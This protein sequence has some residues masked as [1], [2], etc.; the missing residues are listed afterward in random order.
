MWREESFFSFF[1]L[2]FSFV[3]VFS[4]VREAEKSGLV[5]FHEAMQGFG[6]TAIT[7]EEKFARFEKAAAKGHEESIW[8]CSVM[9]DVDMNKNALIE[10]FAN[11]EKPLGW[12]LAGKLFEWRSRESIDFYKKSAEAGCSWGQDLYGFLFRDGGEFVEKDTAVYLEWMEKAVKQNNPSTMWSL[13]L[14]F[15]KWGGDDKEKAFFYYRSGAEL[16]SKLS[17]HKLGIML[18]TGE[19]CEKDLRQGAV[20]SAKSGFHLPFFRV[21]ESARQ[22]FETG[23]TDEL[24][25][26]F[27]QLCYTLGWGA[28]WY[29]Y[30]SDEWNRQ[31]NKSNFF[32]IRCLDYYCSCVELQQKSIFT[33]LWCWNRTTGVKG[34]G[35]M[36]GQMVWEQREENLVSRFAQSDEEEPETKRIKK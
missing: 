25:C 21:L 30:G 5:L 22:A 15:G 7:F 32:D 34:P 16:G 28:Y 2:F 18:N 9:K 26:D 31:P 33:F 11:T 4:Q 3:F 23:T 35:Q 36:I 10:A 29:Q 6:G 14:W 8:V 19:G 17:M 12:Y 1:F 20:W 13:G 24:D 27:D